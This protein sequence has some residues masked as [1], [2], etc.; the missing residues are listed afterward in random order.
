MRKPLQNLVLTAGLLTSA[1]TLAQPTLTAT[2]M[3]PVVGD[4]VNNYNATYVSP[5]S[6][7]A[8]QTWNLAAMGT[9]T[10]NASTGITVSSTP[11]ASNYSAANIA[12]TYAG[13]SEYGYYNT[14]SSA[15]QY[16][17]AAV[18]SGTTTV[19]FI[20]SNPEDFLHFP[21]A[22]NNTYTDTWMATFTSAGSQYVRK[23]N[24][25][26]TADGYGTVTTPAGT[27]SNVMR[28]HFVQ[29]YTDSTNITGFGP[30]VLDYDNDEY[31]WY[32]NNN[33]YPIATV[34]S[35]SATSTFTNSVTQSASYI[36]G[37]IA[38]IE[39]PSSFIA[40]SN[41]FPNPASGNTTLSVTLTENKKVEIKLLNILGA[42]T[43]KTITA[44]GIQGE[45]TY[46]PDIGNL[47][48]GIYFV[49]ISL[50]GTIASTQKLIISK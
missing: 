39:N 38:G 26:V 45:N 24:T 2:G 44:E 42:E 40:S 10:L 47:S 7:G 50:D 34:S 27:F 15:L 14:S 28:I 18:T 25:T 30:Y 21:F 33:H 1:V 16:D 9:G 17:G 43:G 37:V 23:G 29:I 41:L 19:E 46:K 49:Q 8:S 12:F 11:Y 20:Y 13:G 48:E 36:T 35:F 6:A 31:M 22:Y 4:H 3:N 32:L 5:G